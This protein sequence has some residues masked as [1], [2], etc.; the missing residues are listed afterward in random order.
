[1]TPSRAS[2]QAA[3]GALALGLALAGCG[4]HAP[5]P[6]P[7]PA[8]GARPVMAVLPLENLSVRPENGDRLTRV[9]WTALG[10]SGRFEVVESGEVEGAIADVRLR[11]VASVTRD[12]LLRIAKQTNARWLLAGT[13]LECGTVRTPD[14]EVPSLSLAL[15]V[16]DGGTG[17][18]VWT[19]MR[20]HSGEDRETIFG[21]G[22]ETSLER[23]ADRTTRELIDAIR[24]PAA[25]DSLSQGGERR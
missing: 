23:L 20:A 14:G 18:V 21:W 3:V 4:A 8:P 10:S 7:V 9:V 25:V 22:R 17:R 6:E 16:L 13:I 12:Q 2:V 24:L 11:T 1:V 5:A 15:R 19:G